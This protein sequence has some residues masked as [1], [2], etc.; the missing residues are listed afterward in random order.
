MGRAAQP[1]RPSKR[2]VALT[3]A[4]VAGFEEDTRAFTRLLVESR[5]NREAMHEAWQAGVA[6][7]REAVR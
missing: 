3:L 4:R 5:V 2:T 6:R 7:R 1:K